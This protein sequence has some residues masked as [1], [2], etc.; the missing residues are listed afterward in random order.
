MKS[1]P[2]QPGIERNY[3]KFSNSLFEHHLH[4]YT[5]ALKKHKIK[6]IS[7]PQLQGLDYFMRKF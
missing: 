5:A 2:L 4:I 6:P 1:L 3:V 7:L